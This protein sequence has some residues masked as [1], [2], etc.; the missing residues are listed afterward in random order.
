MADLEGKTD[1]LCA[2]S[3]QYLNDEDAKDGPEKSKPI[4]M[5]S[6]KALKDFF[7]VATKHEI[8][9]N[10]DFSPI[11]YIYIY[12]IYIYMIYIYMIYIYIYM[13]VR[14]NIYVF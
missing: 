10:G 13:V 1:G 8:S 6:L 11:T 4:E 5:M 2:V 7:T 12:M 14:T 3:S 9:K